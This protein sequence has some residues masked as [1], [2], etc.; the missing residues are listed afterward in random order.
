ML[1]LLITFYYESGEHRGVRNTARKSGAFSIIHNSRVLRV[2][3][4]AALSE[5]RHSAEP[6]TKIEERVSVTVIR[7]PVWA[8]NQ[9]PALNTQVEKN[10]NLSGLKSAAAAHSTEQK[11]FLEADDALRLQILSPSRKLKR[12]VSRKYCHDARLYRHP[13][14]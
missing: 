12:R 7:Q 9:A 13:V 6:Y 14:R 3:A 11:T 8:V 10:K 2:A 1:L 4:A 5:W